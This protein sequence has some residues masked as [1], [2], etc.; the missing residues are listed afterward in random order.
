M[1]KNNEILNSFLTCMN[2][3]VDKL[4]Q[5][6]KKVVDIDEK[7]NSISI[8]NLIKIK[9]EINDISGRV[10]ELEIG[11][12]NTIMEKLEE[13]DASLKTITYNNEYSLGKLTEVISKNNSLNSDMILVKQQCVNINNE[14]NDL[15]SKYLNVVNKHELL[16]T[17]VDNVKIDVSILSGNNAALSSDVSYFSGLTKDNLEKIEQLKEDVNSMPSNLDF[18]EMT[19]DIEDMQNS[20]NTLK[21]KIND[22]ESNEFIVQN[23]NENT[24]NLKNYNK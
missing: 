22:V 7:F 3:L 20:I 10:T 9:D 8:D 19:H 12:T 21:A 18:N 2:M 5:T 15:G 11:D 23:L 16:D 13:F 17:K 14:I 1:S 4:H 6:N 24:L